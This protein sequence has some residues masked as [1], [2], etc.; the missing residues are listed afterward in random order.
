MPRVTA[1]ARTDRDTV[2]PHDLKAKGSMRMAG[3]RMELRQFWAP[4]LIVLP[5][6]LLLS[7]LE[8]KGAIGSSKSNEWI[9]EGDAI[10]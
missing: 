2:S 10:N 3:E 5:L 6:L 8:F 1:N 4:C 7:A 9:G